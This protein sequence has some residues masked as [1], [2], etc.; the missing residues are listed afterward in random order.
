MSLILVYHDSRIAVIAA[1]ERITGEDATG[2]PMRIGLA[3]KFCTLPGGLILA[4]TGQRWL[5]HKLLVG[6]MRMMA[7]FPKTTFAELAPYLH[8]TCEK[9]WA[10][11]PPT[12]ILPKFRN[13]QAT[14]IG[15][16]AVEGRMRCIAW[17]SNFEFKPY[18]SAD[19]NSRI[20]A[21]GFFEESDQPALQNLTDAMALAEAKGPAWIRRSVAQDRRQHLE[22]SSRLRRS[23]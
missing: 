14:L 7:E 12:Q 23:R 20:L 22:S 3:P 6:T 13:L 19:P 8:F 18:E 16:D 1:D 21:A 15:F 10:D 9:M 2:A 5:T 11:R 17:F 4:C